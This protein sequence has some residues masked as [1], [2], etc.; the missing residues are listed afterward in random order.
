LH[1]DRTR[2]F[3]ATHRP[4]HCSGPAPARMARDRTEFIH[5]KEAIMIQVE[6]LKDLGI[7]DSLNKE[8][9]SKIASIAKTRTYLS[10]TRIY[11][12][13]ER[14]LRLFIV[15]EGL[16]NLTLFNPGEG[17]EIKFGTRSRGDLFGGASFVKPQ[18]HTVTA[19]CLKDSNLMIIE[20]SDLWDLFREDPA[21]GYQFMKEIAQIYFDRYMT[22][23]GYLSGALSAP[24]RIMAQ[25]G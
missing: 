1:I 18:Q 15:R 3:P 25:S 10:G 9:Q 13:R 23:I 17:P 22:A 5:S 8:Q 2:V 4:A 20:T 19:E 14:A 16:V 24:T 11:L 12:S 21:F 7:F 6:E